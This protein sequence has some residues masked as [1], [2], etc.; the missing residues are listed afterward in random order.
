MFHLGDQVY[1]NKEFDN[2][3]TVFRRHKQVG[4]LE[5]AK[6]EHMVKDTI[7]DTYRFTW[8]LPYTREVYANLPH[9]MIWS[10]NGKYRIL[11]H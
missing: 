11:S 3:W 1:C 10:D 4:K 9:L 5:R 6:L 7:R 8:G 2:G